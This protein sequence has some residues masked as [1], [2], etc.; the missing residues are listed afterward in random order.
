VKTGRSGRTKAGMRNNEG[1]LSSGRLWGQVDR[2]RQGDPVTSGGS[3]CC[4]SSCPRYVWT[5][6]PQTSLP[7][8]S[9]AVGQLRDVP[10]LPSFILAPLSVGLSPSLTPRPQLNSPLIPD[11]SLCHMLS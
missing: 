3:L 5:P 7:P 11:T 6:P 1:A 10:Q 4:H 8:L 2:E 9:S